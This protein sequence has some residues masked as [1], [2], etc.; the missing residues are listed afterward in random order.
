MPQIVTIRLR[1]ALYFGSWSM[2]DDEFRENAPQE[3]GQRHVIF[4]L[5]GV[6]KWICLPGRLP[7]P[8]DPKCEAEGGSFHIVAL[9]P[10]AP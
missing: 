1:R 7:D 3:A 8:R 9:F 10:T 6:G 4:Y 5:K 2:V